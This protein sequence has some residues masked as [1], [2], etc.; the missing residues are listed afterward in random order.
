MTEHCRIPDLTEP[1]F[2]SC[3]IWCDIRGGFVCFNFCLLICDFSLCVTAVG[4]RWSLPVTDSVG[5]DGKENHTITLCLVHSVG[6][7]VC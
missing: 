1:E 5:E 4:V 6:G 7:N 2:C 3:A